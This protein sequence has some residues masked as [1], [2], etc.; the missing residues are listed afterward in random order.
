MRHT[1]HEHALRKI[2]GSQK[3]RSSSV[4]L[5]SAVLETS[6]AV[7]QAQL[8]MRPPGLRRERE[9]SRKAKRQSMQRY[10]HGSPLERS[11]KSLQ[12]HAKME[13]IS[14]LKLPPSDKGA[15]RLAKVLQL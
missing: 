4:P 6:K 3:R 10:C 15:P 2:E 5:L 12:A 9:E 7:G 14:W 1:R 13:K 11:K 8:V